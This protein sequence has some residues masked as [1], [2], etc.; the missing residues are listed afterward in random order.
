MLW[1]V[2]FNVHKCQSVRVSVFATRARPTV[3]YLFV[4][5]QFLWQPYNYS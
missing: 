5:R 2:T 3:T 1:D 4:F